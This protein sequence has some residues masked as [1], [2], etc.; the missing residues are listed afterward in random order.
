MGVRDLTMADLMQ[1]AAGKAGDQGSLSPKSEGFKID[2]LKNEV[3]ELKIKITHLE[4]EN[5][6][7]HEQL[8]TG[9]K[10][11]GQ[12]KKVE[13]MMADCQKQIEETRIE[14]ERLQDELDALIIE[15]YEGFRVRDER[16]R[17]LEAIGGHV[18]QSRHH[19]GET[20]RRAD[21]RTASSGAI[22]RGNG[23]AQGEAAEGKARGVA[24]A[25]AAASPIIGWINESWWLPK[26]DCQAARRA[27]QTT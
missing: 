11:R 20:G 16:I 4:E 12:I 2:K 22:A 13:Q 21:Q 19:Y 23:E 3:E 14:N 18:W 25:D 10:R 7:L 8:E 15:R 1:Y 5:S 17:E 26:Q 27:Y 24:V 6:L 9:G